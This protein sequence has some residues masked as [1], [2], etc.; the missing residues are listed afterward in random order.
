MIEVQE[1]ISVGEVEDSQNSL[2]LLYL[3][4]IVKISTK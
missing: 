3:P 1:R 4:C 2:Q